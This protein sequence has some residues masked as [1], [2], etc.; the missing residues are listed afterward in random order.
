[1]LDRAPRARDVVR[2]SKVVLEL[3]SCR[4]GG[5]DYETR[6]GG[7]GPSGAN[8]VH[9]IFDIGEG[10]AILWRSGHAIVTKRPTYEAVEL[11]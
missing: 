11:D 3:L 10:Y 4:S 9:A 5:A 7:D 2:R 6:V 1:M 8:T